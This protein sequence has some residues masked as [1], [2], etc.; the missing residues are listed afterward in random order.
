MLE[1]TMFNPD[2]V[3]FLLYLGLMLVHLWTMLH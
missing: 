2:T 1:V 3:E